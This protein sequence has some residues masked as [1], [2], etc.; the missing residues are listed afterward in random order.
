[1]FGTRWGV[2]R[3]LAIFPSQ[4]GVLLRD[5]VVVVVGF[6]LEERVGGLCWVVAFRLED[7]VVRSSWIARPCWD[8]VLK[9][10]VV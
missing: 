9:L 5:V 7:G 1:M 10:S 6:A 2:G 4:R 3:V 8:G